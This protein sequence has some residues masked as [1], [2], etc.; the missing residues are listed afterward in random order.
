MEEARRME[1]KDYYNDEV[2]ILEPEENEAILSVDDL[3]DITIVMILDTS[4]CRHVM[5]RECAPGC[6]VQDSAH[7]R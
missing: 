1:H 7:S 6:Q 3:Q 4:A 5:P 2:G